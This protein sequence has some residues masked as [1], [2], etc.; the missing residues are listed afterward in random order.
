MRKFLSI[1]ITF[2]MVLALA[3]PAFA[4]EFVPSISMKPPLD[5][6]IMGE[7]NN[8]PWYGEIVDEN[9]EVIQK[10]Y[11]DDIIVTPLAE[12]DDADIPQDAKELL[13]EV[14]EDLMD[15]TTSLED[16]E[17]LMEKVKEALGEEAV[18]DD[19][20]IRDL[21][22]VTVVDP[23]AIELLAEGNRLRVTFDTDFDPEDF[24]AVMTYDDGWKLAYD[25]VI[26]EDGTVTVILEKDGPVAFLTTAREMYADGE[27][28][29]ATG[30]T[31]NI[32]LWAGAGVAAAAL[33]VLLMRR[34]R[35]EEI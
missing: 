20:V 22:D 31:T 17:G 4:T 28:I 13:K 2:M 21:F 10:L 7:E 27:D 23:D 12:I 24:L 16:V 18:A 15:G 1:C 34:R 30:D 8:E 6:D 14:Y 9:G 32:A 35:N 25:Y 11:E 29:P 33:L 19:L 26:N 3:A 5:L